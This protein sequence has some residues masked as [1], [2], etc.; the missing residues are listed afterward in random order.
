MRNTVSDSNWIRD[1]FM[2]KDKDAQQLHQAKVRI[3]STVKYKYTNSQLG[4]SFVINPWPQFSQRA[5][6]RH[7]NIYGETTHMG[8]YYSE[9]IDDHQQVV[10]FRMGV[11]KFNSLTTF[12]GAFYSPSANV[13]A[14]QGRAP[15]LFFEMG[16]LAGSV[17]T[18]GLAPIMHVGKMLRFFTDKPAS[19]Y[20]YLKPTMPLYWN[21]VS[22]IVNTITVN[23]GIIPRIFPESANRLNDGTQWTETDAKAL[24]KML[25]GIIREDG[26]IDI[27]ALSTRAQRLANHFNESMEEYLNNSAKVTKDNPDQGIADFIGES[28]T[29]EFISSHWTPT[30]AIE[31]LAEV[32]D[33]SMYGTI[34]GLLDRYLG[35]VDGQPKG[36]DQSKIEGNDMGYEGESRDE[37]WVNSM[38]EFFQGERKMGGDFISF[39]VDHTGTNTESFSNSVKEPSIVSTINSTSSEAREKRFNIA[40]GNLAANGVAGMIGTAAQMAKDFIGGLSE[41]FGVAG[42]AALAGN[43]FIDI[44]DTWDSSTADVGRT[45]LNIPLRA[46]YGHDFSRLQNLIVPMSALMAMALPLSSGKQSYTSPFI[47]EMYNEGRTQISLGMVESLTFTRGVGDVGW[48]KGSRYMAVDCQ[49]SIVDLSKIVHMPIAPNFSLGQAATMAVTDAVVDG[50]A[51]TARLLGMQEQTIEDMST[52]ISASMMPSTFDDDN[53]YTQY[54]AVLGSLPMEAQINTFRKF[55]LRAAQQRAQFNAWKSPAHL[56]QW[57]MGGFFGDVI[58]AVSVATARGGNGD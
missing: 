34:K 49:L 37:G 45:T 31:E 58:K 18:I 53:K 44:P 40:D 47:L 6:I 29:G 16:R 2:L 27:Y 36:K 24:G 3:H 23:M 56:T 21:A 14:R 43:A 9:A 54:L 12:F 22:T 26:G 39:R 52:A 10:H 19:R 20:Y 38:L 13:L 46:P 42:I 55:K 25:P 33:E 57:A 35:T 7:T 30:K 5:D 1:S 50:S 15:S 8:R 17:V 28:A 4:G 41:K 51:G 11:P 32:T 48:I